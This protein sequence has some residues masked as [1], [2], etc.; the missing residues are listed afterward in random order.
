M[1]LN[2]LRNISKAA[3][4][5]RAKRLLKV[6]KK[7]GRTVR[8]AVESYADSKSTDEPIIEGSYK[9]VDPDVTSEQS[10]TQ[11]PNQPEVEVTIIT[12]PTPDKPADSTDQD[13]TTKQKPTANE[14]PTTSQLNIPHTKAKQNDKTTQSTETPPD[15]GRPKRS[16]RFK[17]FISELP[18]HIQ[19]PDEL[20]QLK[21]KLFSSETVTMPQ[22]DEA[23]QTDDKFRS[24]SYTNEVGSR[25]Y[26]LYV[27][28]GYHGQ[29]VPLMV[30]LHGCT[31]SPDDFAA[32]TR[33]NELAEEHTFLV[34]YPVQSFKANLGKCWNWFKESE[35]QRDLGEPAIIAGMTREIIKNYNLD[36]QRVYV[37]GISAGGAMAQTMAMTYPDLYAAV[38]IHSGV[39]Y[40][41]A[42]NIPTGIAAIRGMGAASPE[43]LL[44]AAGTHATR[45]VVPTIIFHG[46]EDSAVTPENADQMIAQ[47]L[48]IREAQG[49]TGPK[50]QIT[51]HRGQVP[52][53]HAYT[54]SVYHDKT[55]PSLAEKWLVH[56]AGHAWSGGNPDIAF[57]DGRGP[58]AS[59]EMLRFFYEHPM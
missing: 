13:S 24:G 52:A 33:M 30:M 16:S 38:G 6:T 10:S 47:W 48:Q 31:Q 14:E 49:Y 1:D 45:R 40:G 21:D 8:D 5:E 23:E 9:V 39:A 25:S 53:G 15:E 50:P 56:G 29:A 44:N 18:L 36:E 58:N 32:S 37:A 42:H 57:T 2:K 27:P 34:L 12:E 19:V 4:R 41:V 20:K 35:Q 59:Q 3:R 11:S 46:D 54:R 43:Q 28:T 7:I 22:T 26:K 55:G 51:V 17:E